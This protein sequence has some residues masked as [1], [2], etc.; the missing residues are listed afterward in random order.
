MQTIDAILSAR[1][2]THACRE[3]IR[4][5][6]AGGVDAMSVKELKPYLDKNRDALTEL[7]RQGE[8][9]PQ[10]IRGKEIPKSNNKLR[11]L[12]IPTVVDRMLQQAAVRIIIASVRVYV[13]TV[14]LW[15]PTTAQYPS[16]NTEIVGLYKFRFSAYC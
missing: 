13:F 3:V 5:K 6:G 15:I 8:Y 1:N 10:P 4:N 14:Q 16:G 12:G 7:I 2:L 9:Y 11:L